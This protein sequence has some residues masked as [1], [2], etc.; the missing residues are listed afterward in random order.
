M[1]T[2]T[3]AASEAI[4][5]LVQSS[6]LPDSAGIRIGRGTETP[7]GV[8]LDLELVDTPGDRDQVVSDERASVFVDSQLGDLLDDKVLDAQVADG[9]VAF[10][11]RADEHPHDHMGEGDGQGI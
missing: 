9:Q 6:E 5:Q 7:E 3:P 8:S 11:L 10:A 2:I 4:R 1:L